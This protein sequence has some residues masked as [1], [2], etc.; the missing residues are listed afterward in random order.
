MTARFER[1][2]FLKGVGAATSLA[3][4]TA[5]GQSAAPAA[6]TDAGPPAAKTEAKPAE[7][8]PAQQ[9][10]AKTSGGGNTVTFWGRQ[11]FLPESNTWL[12]ESVQMA[13]KEGGFDVK[14]E[15]FSNDDHV[16]KE[17]VAMEA[18]QLPDVTMTTSA[19]LWYQNG[20]GLDV[21]DIYDEVGKAGGG[22]FDAP[23]KFSLMNGKR[24]GVPLNV[25]PWLMHLRKDI[26]SQ[27]GVSVPFKSYEEMVDGFK[28]VTKG[29][30][31]G[32][33]GQMTSPDFAGNL[34]CATMAYGGRWFDTDGKPTINTPKN[35]EG[36]AAYTDLFTKHKVMPQGVVQ[37]DASGN[38][39]AW[40]AGQVAAVSNT[41]SIILAMR[42]D[43]PEMLRNTLLMPW[44]GGN[45]NPP[46]TTADGFM[47]VINK[48]TPHVD[49]AKQIIKKIL[50]KERYPGN[51]EAAGSYWFSVLKDH[52]NIDFF[53]KDEWNKQIQQDIIPYAIAPFAE[54][55]RNPIFD[56]LGISAVGD[57]MQMVAVNG[58]TAQ[59][60]ISYLDDKAKEAAA[61]FN[62]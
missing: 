36:F 12:T 5:C 25:E 49:K 31:Y 21:P 11:Q 18:R 3:L 61:K 48:N 22:W 30:F 28:K 14:V 57:A 1:R 51:L 42:K 26:F 47:L 24:I 2:A 27:A 41:G 13:A 59:E 58:K 37:W 39:K 50:S 54:G 23:E 29:G 60:G 56:D 19:A 35:L 8:K 45:G 10:P 6:K 7:A 53:T 20:F 34:L 43:N 16:Q 62:K 17:V 4:L 55:G 44:P 38:N 15:L 9:A 32:F 33:G 52:A 40:L 46:A